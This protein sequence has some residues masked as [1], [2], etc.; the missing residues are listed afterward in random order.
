MAYVIG[1]ACVSC[2]ACQGQCPVGAI[3]ELLGKGNL[4]KETRKAGR[5]KA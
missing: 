5:K 2:G 4:R 3:G 1:D